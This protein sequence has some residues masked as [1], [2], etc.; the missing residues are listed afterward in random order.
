MKDFIFG[1]QQGLELLENM[2]QVI[3]KGVR[4]DSRGDV[5]RSK[6]KPILEQIARLK[7]YLNEKNKEIQ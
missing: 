3:L 1:L 7:E 5:L 6:V 2:T 4:P